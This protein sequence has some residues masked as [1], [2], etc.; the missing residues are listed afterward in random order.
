[1]MQI[2]IILMK[3]V[4]KIIHQNFTSRKG[5]TKPLYEFIR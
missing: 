4:T 5:F 2:F 1:M 3:M